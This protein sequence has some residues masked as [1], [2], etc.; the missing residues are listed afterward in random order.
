[1]GL[2][3]SLVLV[4]AL[5]GAQNGIVVA[6][7]TYVSL[8]GQTYAITVVS[9]GPYAGR[10]EH[11]VVVIVQVAGTTVCPDGIHPGRIAVSGRLT[12]RQQ[13]KAILHETVHAATLC[14]PR[15]LSA[16][17]RIAQDVADLLASP[18]GR[19]VLDGLRR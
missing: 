18:E 11:G 3:A 7:S 1:M 6:Q 17:E 15:N 19:F 12:A 2:A 4:L 5:S 8:Y 14:D 13:A 10:M 16:E 9:D